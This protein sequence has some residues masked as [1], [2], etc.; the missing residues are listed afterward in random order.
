MVSSHP[1]SS[2]PVQFLATT[3][4]RLSDKA[5]S[6]K[7]SEFCQTIRRFQ[8]RQLGASGGRSSR[9]GTRAGKRSWPMPA[10]RIPH[11]Q[12]GTLSGADEQSAPLRLSTTTGPLDRFEDLAINQVQLQMPKPQSPP[13][14]HPPV[15]N[16]VSPS[17]EWIRNSCR[18]RRP[19]QTVSS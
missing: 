12:A 13:P 6:A 14:L 10:R 19:A 15:G 8:T 3:I 17:R 4:T 5:S 1:P 11:R 2:Q 7:Q 9:P 18:H 16:A